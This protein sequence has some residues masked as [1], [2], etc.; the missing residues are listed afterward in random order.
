VGLRESQLSCG[1]HPS[2]W[3]HQAEVMIREEV[4]ATP[5][6]SNCSGKHAGLLA[7]ATLHGWPTDGYEA[8][9]HPVQARVAETVARW[10]GVPEAQLGWGVDG[11]TAAAVA[12]PLVAMARAYAALGTG[13]STELARLRD[14]MMDWPMLVAGSERIDT[15]LMAAWPGRVLA[16]IGAEGVFSAAL[17]TLGVG[18]TLK[19]HDGDMRCAG[20]ALIALLEQ[21]VTRLDPAGDW[22]M[23][24]L[25][26][27]QRPTIRNTRGVV[28]GGYEAR[29][30]WHFTD[31]EGG[32]R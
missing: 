17:P 22:P 1:G 18:L 12:L 9:D 32:N 8:L 26:A 5:L 21:L 29:G 11:C 2:L 3:S 19:V 20:F 13:R 16:K 25:A 31:T 23:E 7:L 14:A 6:W 28:T 30:G 10:T 4:T 15:V 27:W 24:P